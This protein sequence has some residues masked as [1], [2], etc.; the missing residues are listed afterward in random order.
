[1]TFEA[2]LEILTG[3][4]PS[5]KLREREEELFEMIPELRLCRGFDQ[6]NIWHVYDVYGHIMCVLDSTPADPV[7]RL[8]ALFHDTGK[9]AACTEDAD[10]V[11]HFRG[12]WTA[13][14]DIFLRFAKKYSV[15]EALLSETSKLILYHDADPDRLTPEET[16]T[17]LSL[18]S[19]EDIERLFLFKSCD[20]KAQNPIFHEKYSLLQKEQ[21]ER[22]LKA[23]L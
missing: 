4:S 1:M 12:H 15:P 21:K 16:E 7:M 11:R 20:L 8:A 9:P 6:K 10:G 2:L 22:L 14:R 3:D 23:R 19:D 18:F 17:F 13:S 5:L